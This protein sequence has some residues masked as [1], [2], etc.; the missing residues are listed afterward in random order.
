[1]SQRTPSHCVAIRLSSPSI[2]SCRAGVAVVQL[3]RVGPAVEVRVAAVGEDAASRPRRRPRV[4][5]RLVGEELLVARHEPVR[6]LGHPRV[7]RRH[8]VRDEVEDEPQAPLAQAPAEAGERRVAAEVRVDPVVADREAGAADV[9]LAE[10]GQDAPV[11]GPPPLVRGR[12]APRRLARLPDAEEPDE[13]EAVRREAVELGVGDVV[14]RRRPSERRGELGQPDPRVDL[15]ERG[16]TRAGHRRASYSPCTCSRTRR[17]ARPS[18]AVFRMSS[19][20]TRPKRSMSAAIVP[21][22]P[23]WWLAPRPAPLSPWKYS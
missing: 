7:V 1:M 22:Q 2:A 20:L 21:V 17:A 10:V 6:V 16:V 12:D 4:V 13:V 8:V 3:E 23:V 14:E 18:F 15:E 19:P 5:L 11:L 9:R